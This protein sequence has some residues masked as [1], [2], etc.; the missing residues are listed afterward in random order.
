MSKNSPKIIKNRF[1]DSYSYEIRSRVRR[2]KLQE[3]RQCISH[4]HE[5]STSHLRGDLV[6]GLPRAASL[7]VESHKNALSEKSR[8][9]FGMVA[10]Y[11]Q[12]DI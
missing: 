9:S 12:L 10:I 6:D 1:E 8:Q 5:S 11:D 4:R 3:Q 2:D 7:G